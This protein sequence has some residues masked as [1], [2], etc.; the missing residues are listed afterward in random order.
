MG[1]WIQGNKLS[2]KLREEVLLRWRKHAIVRPMSDRAYLA[3][4]AF[5]INW[6]GSLDRTVNYC[7]PIYFINEK[8]RIEL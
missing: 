6:R 7:V 3:Q 5:R 2:P 8:G 4:M 1:R